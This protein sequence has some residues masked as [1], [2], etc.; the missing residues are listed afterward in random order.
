MKVQ[1]NL[2][3]KPSSL[4]FGWMPHEEA[5]SIIDNLLCNYNDLHADKSNRLTYRYIPGNLEI[6]GKQEWLRHFCLLNKIDFDVK[7]SFPPI[8]QH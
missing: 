7:Y 8:P 6:R 5:L 4:E 3:N 1:L 2:I